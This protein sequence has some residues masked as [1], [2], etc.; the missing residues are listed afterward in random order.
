MTSSKQPL[1]VR[2][3]EEEEAFMKVASETHSE[4]LEGNKRH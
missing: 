2:P 3:G 4:N 1:P